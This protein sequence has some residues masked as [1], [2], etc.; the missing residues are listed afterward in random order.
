MNFGKKPI[1]F[2]A[3]DLNSNK[4][5]F[6]LKLVK[7]VYFAIYDNDKNTKANSDLF[8]S[9]LDDDVVFGSK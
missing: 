2:Y 8:S 4:N 5:L 3:I 1:G 7:A 9:S 6:L